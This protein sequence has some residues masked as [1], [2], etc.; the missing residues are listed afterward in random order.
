MNYTQLSVPVQTDSS[1]NYILPVLAKPIV[2][3]IVSASVLGV[4]TVL[5]SDP[6]QTQFT[7]TLAGSI[8]N[9][10]PFDATILF[11]SG[12]TVSWN[13]S[14]LGSL[15]LSPVDVVGDVG[16]TIQATSAFMV[17][18]VG[19]LTDFTKVLL[20]EESFEWDI[21]GEN[22]TGLLNGCLFVRSVR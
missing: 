9:A 17:A 4:D 3:K 20:T 6:E 12:L 8:T 2:Q 5:I 10:G 11:P 13:G 7:T 16:A 14:P 1:L 19:H 15:Q 22:L 21:S 18:D